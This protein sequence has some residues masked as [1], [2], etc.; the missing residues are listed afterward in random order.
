MRGYTN[1][2]NI[3]NGIAAKLGI[4]ISRNQSILWANFFGLFKADV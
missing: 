3:H 2:F 4:D 1:K